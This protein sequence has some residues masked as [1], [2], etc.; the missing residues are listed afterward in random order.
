MG[1]SK[2]Y[3]Y[4]PTNKNRRKKLKERAKRLIDNTDMPGNQKVFLKL[5]LISL[6]Q[7]YAE[8]WECR[9]TKNNTKK[10][11]SE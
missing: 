1:I 2:H 9:P 10:E 3:K 8:L 4:D 6:L 5:S 7:E 11:D